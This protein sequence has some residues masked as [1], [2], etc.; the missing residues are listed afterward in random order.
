M[1][2]IDVGKR[3]PAIEEWLSDADRLE[4]DQ[5]PVGETRFW[6]LL[7]EVDVKEL[8]QGIVSAELQATAARCLAPITNEDDA[9]S[10]G[11]CAD[12]TRATGSP[13]NPQ[14]GEP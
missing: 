8:S 9:L 11:R 12:A 4:A 3:K 10:R 2:V 7:E 1:L 6:F 13:R 5:W 14:R